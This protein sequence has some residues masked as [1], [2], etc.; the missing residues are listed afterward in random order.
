M[1]KL[2]GKKM[3][4]MAPPA[5]SPPTSG[6]GMGGMMG[7]L[8]PMPTVPPKAVAPKPKRTPV[9]KQKGMALSGFAPR[10][11]KAVPK[12]KMPKMAGNPFKKP[13]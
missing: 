10:A 12:K 3:T 5:G 1:A 4:G 11:K 6:M 9:M 8:P 7:K 13:F 2:F